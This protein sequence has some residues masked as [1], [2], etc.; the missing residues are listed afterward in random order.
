VFLALGQ[1]FMLLGILLQ[2][3]LHPSLLF[4]L[5]HEAFH[6]FGKHRNISFAGVFFNSGFKGKLAFPS[7]FWCFCYFLD[8]FYYLFVIYY[9][10]FIL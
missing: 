9:G 8:S 5:P 6:F 1:D 10:D 4:C 3:Y 2:A 7:L